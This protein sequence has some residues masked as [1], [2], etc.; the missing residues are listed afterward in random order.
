MKNI[1][2]LPYEIIKLIY[3]YLVGICE[4]CYDEY[5][6]DQLNNDVLYNEI[7]MDV[8]SKSYIYNLYFNYICDSCIFKLSLNKNS[9]ILYIEK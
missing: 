1:N 9:Y 8:E 2:I 3:I 4:I 6:F 7:C 5:L